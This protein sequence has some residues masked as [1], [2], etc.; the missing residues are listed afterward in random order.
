M[1]ERDC[2][3][4]D[5]RKYIEIIAEHNAKRFICVE[6]EIAFDEEDK[7]VEYAV[8]EYEECIKKKILYT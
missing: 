8:L 3:R 5:Y 2:Q 4:F 6:F 7:L 1:S